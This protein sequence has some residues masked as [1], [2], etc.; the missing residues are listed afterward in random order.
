M[1]TKDFIGVGLCISKIMSHNDVG[2]DDVRVGLHTGQD[3]AGATK[4]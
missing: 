1:M 2:H 4:V 3:D